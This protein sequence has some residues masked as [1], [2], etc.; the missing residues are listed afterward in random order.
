MKSYDIVTIT[1]VIVIISIMLYV[2]GYFPTNGNVPENFTATSETPTKV[3]PEVIYGEIKEGVKAEVINKP[4]GEIAIVREEGTQIINKVGETQKCANQ[5]LGK[6][7]AVTTNINDK[8]VDIGKFYSSHLHFVRT[9][10]EDPMLRGANLLSMNNFGRL[11]DIGRIPMKNSEGLAK[12]IGFVFE[13]S[14]V[15]S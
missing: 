2:N 8:D 9:Y 5:T 4:N 1:L 7:P 12:P 10:L 13:N 11:S 14:T 3:T 6:L 15:Y